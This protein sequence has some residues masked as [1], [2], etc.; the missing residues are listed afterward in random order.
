V[1]NRPHFKRSEATP[2]KPSQIPK[3]GNASLK[4]ACELIGMNEK[5]L[6][7]R[8]IKGDFPGKKVG[9]CGNSP[10]RGSAK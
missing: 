6:R 4:Q 9:A 10:G 2:T 3:V 8:S 5:T 1:T 7:D